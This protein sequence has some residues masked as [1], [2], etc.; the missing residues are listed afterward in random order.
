MHPRFNKRTEHV[1]AKANGGQSR[2][3]PTH[4]QP[5][6]HDLAT[7][8]YNN[9][10]QTS[11]KPRTPLVSKLTHQHTQSKTRTRDPNRLIVNLFDTE[12]NISSRTLLEKGLSFFIASRRI[13]VE[14]IICSFKDSIKHLPENEAEEVRQN[15]ARTLRRAKPPKPN[16]SNEE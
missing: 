2:D 10:Q 6:D 15:C 11:L 5:L 12:L 3:E 1:L 8:R 9:Q 4:D 7:R 13:P 14:D 16:I